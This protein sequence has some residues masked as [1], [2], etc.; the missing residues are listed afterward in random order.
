MPVADD[1]EEEV[2]PIL[3][4]GQITEFV[5]HQEVRR[6]IILELEVGDIHRFPQVGNYAS[7]CRCVNAD[8]VSNNRVKGKGNAKNGNKYLS[9]AYVAAA[10][11]AC[12][13]YSAPGRFY[14]RKRS[15]TNNN[16]AIKALANKLAR[17]SYWMMKRKEPYDEMRLFR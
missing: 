1:L 8:W 17:A 10:N 6:L 3:A 7:Y 13:N 11:F 4:Q 16:V 5:D 12:R 15:K 14:Q 2:G 9:W